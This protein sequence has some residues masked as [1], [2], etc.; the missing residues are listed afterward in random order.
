MLVGCISTPFHPLRPPVFGWKMFLPNKGIYGRMGLLAYSFLSGWINLKCLTCLIQSLTLP[1]HLLRCN[2][3]DAYERS[4]RLL[5]IRSYRHSMNDSIKV[6]HQHLFIK[7]LTMNTEVY[8]KKKRNWYKRR[9]V[10][11]VLLLLICY[12]INMVLYL[13]YQMRGSFYK[14][15]FDY[16]WFGI[17]REPLWWILWNILN[18]VNLAARLPLTRNH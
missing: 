1:W 5:M 4:N 10:L 7:I 18:R 17:Q 3:L 16:W 6:I 13:Y 2:S 14:L 12:F 9:H 11:F 8:G 15:Y